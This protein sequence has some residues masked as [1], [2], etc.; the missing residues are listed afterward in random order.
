MIITIIIIIIIITIISIIILTL[1]QP[2]SERTLFPA[3]TAVFNILETTFPPVSHHE[4]SFKCDFTDE[5]DN[6][7]S[8]LP[9]SSIP[10]SYD[11]F[12]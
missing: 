11:L 6:I 5:S 1:S 2:V 4:A 12:T 9:L 8:P 10:L 3:D 7:F